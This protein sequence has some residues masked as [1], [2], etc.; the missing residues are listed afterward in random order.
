[1]ILLY[2]NKCFIN[3]YDVLRA[4]QEQLSTHKKQEQRN[5][6]QT[7]QLTFRDAYHYSNNL[8][9]QFHHQT[10]THQSL[11]KYSWVCWPSISILQVLIQG[12]LRVVMTHGNS[13][14]N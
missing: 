5:D 2:K 3:G 4:L 11:V 6:Y 14:V 7:H 8:H 9:T 12:W 1:M 13:K 10:A